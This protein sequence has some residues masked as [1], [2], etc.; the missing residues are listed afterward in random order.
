MGRIHIPQAELQAWVAA[1]HHSTIEAFRELGELPTTPILIGVARRW[2]GRSGRVYVAVPLAELVPQLDDHGALARAVAAAIEVE[3]YCLT[4]DT[5]MLATQDPDEIEEFRRDDL[6]IHT[7]PKASEALISVGETHGATP[8]GIVTAYKR[9]PA[10]GAYG[11]TDLTIPGSTWHGRRLNGML[12]P[13]P[14]YP[15]RVVTA[16]RELIE[17]HGDARPLADTPLRGVVT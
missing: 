1:V 16:L 4:S 11:F 8:F 6:P 17:A 14:P 3:A 12:E 5:W 13:W 10:G 15:E 7:H 2:P 9:Y